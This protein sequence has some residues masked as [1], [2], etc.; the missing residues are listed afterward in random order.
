VL[1]FDFG[2]IHFGFNYGMK[3]EFI[4]WNKKDGIEVKKMGEKKKERKMISAFDQ[5]FF[6]IVDVSAHRSFGERGSS[7]FEVRRRG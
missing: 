4:R 7:K 1:P 6:S 3:N 5:K 2:K